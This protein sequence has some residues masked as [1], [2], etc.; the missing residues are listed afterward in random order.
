MNCSFCHGS[1]LLRAPR[2]AAAMVPE[3]PYLAE[4]LSEWADAEIFYVVKH[5][6][7][8]TGM[9]AWP[10]Q[11]RDDEVWAMVAFLRALRGL[12]AT[13][14]RRLVQVDAESEN[15]QD[16]PAVNVCYRCHG[17]SGLGRG[18]NAFPKLAGQ[19]AE[20][21]FL[22]LNAYAEGR[23][24]SGI[25]EPIASGLSHEEMRKVAEYYSS[26]PRTAPPA[27]TATE[28][29]IERGR[30]I[31]ERGIPAQRVPSCSDC[32]GP[33]VSPR[34]SAYPDHSGQ[35]ADYL[36]AQLELFKKKQR[37]GTPFSHL[38]EPVAANLN[39]QQIRDVAVY[40]ASQ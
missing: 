23:R 17:E 1:P 26:L 6:L 2:V 5:G 11:Q 9:P 12:D 28:A 35:Y 21:V 40:Y 29:A 14:Y 20:Y 22:S 18:E 31:A 7:K 25:M 37:G 34:N 10:S 15:T 38:M 27:S 36:I 3:P 24:K 16:V 4:T 13:E 30:E 19:S 8:F 33:G 39:T 32:H